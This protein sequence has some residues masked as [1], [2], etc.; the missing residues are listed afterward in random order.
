MIS[1]RDLKGLE[2]ER[3]LF[4]NIK[5][6]AEKLKVIAQTDV[7]EISYVDIYLPVSLLQVNILNEISHLYTN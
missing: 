6:M 5:E 4:G 1:T 2:L 3:M 7:E